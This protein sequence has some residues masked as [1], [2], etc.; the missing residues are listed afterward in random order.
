MAHGF[1]FEPHCTRRGAGQNPGILPALCPAPTTLKSGVCISA[2]VNSEKLQMGGKTAIFR[3]GL[4]RLLCCVG[5][6]LAPVTPVL[7][8][9]TPIDLAQGNV[10]IQPQHMQWSQAEGEVDY[11]D[12]QA[13]EAYQGETLNGQTGW[14]VFTVTGTDAPGAARYLQVAV[15]KVERLQAWVKLQGEWQQIMRHGLD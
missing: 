14:F 2:T 5:L 8:L 11:S 6:L 9:T 7:A 1:S 10:R 15:P 4:T 3:A 12:G 13:F